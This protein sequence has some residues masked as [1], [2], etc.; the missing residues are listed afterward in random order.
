MKMLVARISL[1]VWL[2]LCVSAAATVLHV[3]GEYETIMAGVL[4]SVDGDTVLV[5]DG[6]Y[7]GLGNRDI[8]FYGREIVVMSE[9]GPEVTI[10]DCEGSEEYPHRGF[11]FDS[12]ESTAAVVQGFT[13]TNGHID[14]GGG[15]LCEDGSSPTIAGNI[16]TGNTAAD[17]WGGGIFCRSMTAPLIVENII[18]SNTAD[19]EG[20]GICCFGG[21]PTIVG[22]TVMGNVADVGGGGI[23]CF[24]ASATIEE[25]RVFGNSADDGGGIACWHSIS[26]SIR[27]N[28][29]GGNDAELGG[30][31]CCYACIITAIEENTITHNT[32]VMGGGIFCAYG[33]AAVRI[34]DNV[35]RENTALG[36]GGGILV[37][38]SSVPVV[39]LGNEI[40]GNSASA[41]GGGLLCK[42]A[43][44]VALA[45]NTLGRNEAGS[46]GG[47]ISLEQASATV[48]NSILWEN[49]ASAGP[50]IY[51]WEGGAVA[52]TYSDIEGGW[53]G[54]GNIDGDPAFVLAAR[55]EYRLR[56][57]SPC[58][59]AGHPDSLDPDGTRG[60]MGAYF[61][62]QNDYLTLYLTPGSS[63][64]EPGGQLP[65]LYT[66][67]NRWEEPEEFWLRTRVVTTQGDTLTV[68]GPEQHVVPGEYTAQVPV[69][70]AVPL[71]APEGDYEY[72]AEI[73]IP[74]ATLYDEDGFRFTVVGQ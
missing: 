64:V 69:I 17:D 72:R 58:I 35:I 57:E 41:N 28:W 37:R 6:T 13:I 9:N 3:P 45:R 8:N 67:I 26:P 14:A 39:L 22:N 38:S 40:A 51:L 30:G 15:I 7:A 19:F 66:V 56:W 11:R 29:I 74:P 18:T 70:H 34:A 24:D 46:H 61:F 25:N 10:I 27:R 55:G 62:D 36:S 16:I 20:G 65:V 52:V 43:S 42:E 2:G 63:E 1:A 68:L 59:D 48:V 50:A 5:A 44:S 23:F 12:G 54:I 60:D 73:G 33:L 53:A 47:G 21:A 49:S 71:L 32:A 4:A 31:I